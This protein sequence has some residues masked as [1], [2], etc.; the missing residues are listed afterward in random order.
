MNGSVIIFSH[1]HDILESSLEFILRSQ[2]GES[3]MHLFSKGE[4]VITRTR[5][6]GHKEQRTGRRNA[7]ILGE[8]C[9]VPRLIVLIERTTYCIRRDDVYE[10]SAA[11]NCNKIKFF[12]YYYLFPLLSHHF[13]LQISL[14]SRGRHHSLSRENGVRSKE[15]VGMNDFHS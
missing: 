6:N 7:P 8:V 13:F 12:L 9:F 2:F 14:T 10:S 5:T 1:Y 11:A 4:S 15:N 3:R